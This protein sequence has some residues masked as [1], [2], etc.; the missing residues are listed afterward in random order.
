MFEPGCGAQ[1]TARERFT[2][3]ST[4]DQFEPLSLAAEDNRVI[5]NGIA[6]PQGH[7]PDRFIR[8]ERR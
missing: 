3:L 5:T 1:R 2:A 4:M 7:H 8:T 6:G